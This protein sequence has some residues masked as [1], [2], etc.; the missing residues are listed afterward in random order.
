MKGIILAGGKSTRLYP[1]TRG[2]CKQ[3][4]PVYNKPMI[5]YPL[6]TLMLAGIRDILLISTPQDTP[7][8]K[9]IFGDGSSLGIRIS[10][11]VQPQPKGIAQAFLIGEEFIQKDQVCLILGDNI[12]Y[13]DKLPELL[14][15]A[16]EQKNGCTIFAYNVKN[17]ERYGVVELDNRMRPTRIVEKPLKSKSS[18]AVTGIYFYD[19]K[20]LELAKKLKPSKRG[21]LEI[22][23]IN[24]HYLTQKKLKIKFL[25]RGYAW[26][27]TGTYES[28]ID[29]SAFIRTIEQRQGLKVSSVEEI[30]FR[31]KFI[32][33]Q[34]LIKTAKAI[35]TEYGEYLLNI[36]K[37]E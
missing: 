21:E 37:N 7:I 33:K 8:F 23:D 19:N 24:Q 2:V 10:Y 18:W 36:A 31:M 15:Q 1:I 22:T 3:L 11:A 4:L 17:P 9:K 27:D 6:S 20:V 28:L 35:P 5:Y 14:I 26:L 16:K 25:G 12:F 30:A 32:T 29:A 13:G 34:Q